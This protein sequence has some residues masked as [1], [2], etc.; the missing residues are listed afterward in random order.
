MK[1]GVPKET[2]RH[3][4]RVGL[5]PF[6]VSRLTSLG[7]EVYV[8]RDAGKDAHFE[9]EDYVKAGATVVY[10]SEEAYGRADLV[11]R[12]G[13]LT[14]DEVHL[15]RPET[16]ICGFLHLAIASKETM[17]RL[18][19]RRISMVGWEI[20]GDNGRRPVLAALSEIAGHMVVHTA[21]HLLET[22]SGG[23]GVIIGSIPGI[24]PATVVILGAGTVGR[25]ASQHF[26]ALGAHVILMDQ[27]ISKL[28]LALEHQ[29]R[30]VVTAVSSPRN[31]ARFTQ[32]ADVVLGCVLVP[33]ARAPFLVSEEMVSRMKPGS[34][35][36]DL[37]IDQGG[38]VE[39]S[40]PTTADHP[41]YKAHGVTHYCV[42]NMTANAPRTASRAMTLAALPFVTRLAEE[43]LEA[44]LRRDPGLARGTYTYRGRLV[45]EV[46]AAALGLA[47]ARLSDLLS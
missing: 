38:C 12:V 18:T 33:G 13:S 40:R 35:I 17:Q 45:N 7:H 15:L 21:G 32:I 37:S 42:P 36:L 29:S 39:T 47:P 20:V 46:A 9:N 10:S 1:I 34:V 41:T 4:H 2:L 6:G 24:A 26:L 25:T 14:A 28:R 31:L 27:D 22:G 19:E 16:T 5:T 43:G 44:G 23:R 30:N 8:E 11:C 3:E